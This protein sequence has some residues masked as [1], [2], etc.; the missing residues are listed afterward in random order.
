[1]EA[2]QGD[3]L[4]LVAHR[5]QLALER[6]DGGVVEMLLPVEAG[7]AVVGQQFA[8]ELGMDGGGKLAGKL[9]VGLAGFAPDQIGIRRVGEAAADRLIQA[10]AGLEEALGGALARSEERREGK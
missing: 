3:E 10:I 1:M 5:C 8:G 9:Q 4:E 2:G 7:R 6:S